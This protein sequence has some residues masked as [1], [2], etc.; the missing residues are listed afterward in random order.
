MVDGDLQDDG[1]IGAALGTDGVHHLE[2]EGHA[3][4][5]IAAILV[6]TFIPRAGQELVGEVA[7]VGMESHTVAPSGLGPGAGL[8]HGV[9]DP[10]NLLDG[11]GDALHARE[12]LS[13][14]IAGG[15]GRIG[16]VLMAH[17]AQ[18]RADLGEELAALLM[19][20]VGAV[21]QTADLLIVLHGGVGAGLKL[22][23]G[24]RAAGK[25]QAGTAL[26]DAGK[27]LG[28]ACDEAAVRADA[29][30]HRRQTDAVG[31]GNITDLDALE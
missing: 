5:Q 14:H 29:A 17:T 3:A 1:E 13:L 22:R 20:A 4:L 26:R 16:G 23:G 2:Q 28:V 24:Q 19:D 25:N 11:E 21:S 27:A 15:V 10:L 18:T 31:D 9:D 30:A 6:G 12:E 7:A 8:R